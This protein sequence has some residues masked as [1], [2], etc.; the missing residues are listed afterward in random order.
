M[1]QFIFAGLVE[2]RFFAAALAALRDTV[3]LQSDNHPGLC[4]PLLHGRGR[5]A[6]TGAVYK[7]YVRT[8][9]LGSVSV[10]QQET[11]ASVHTGRLRNSP[12]PG[13]SEDG[14]AP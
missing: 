8:T 12:C 2:L 3:P 1:K 9:T 6:F 7:E 10:G 5:T 11:A 4:R 14:F 13:D